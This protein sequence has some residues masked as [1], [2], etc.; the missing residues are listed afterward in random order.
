MWHVAGCAEHQ[1]EALCGG[2]DASFSTKEATKEQCA[3][4][5]YNSDTCVAWTFRTPMKRIYFSQVS[6]LLFVNQILKKS[7]YEYSRIS[8]QKKI[9][10]YESESL[11]GI[12][13]RVRIP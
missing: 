11:F 13:K 5:C 6:K 1:G 3:T 10:Q 2:S 4:R 12:V 7:E 9:F 8:D